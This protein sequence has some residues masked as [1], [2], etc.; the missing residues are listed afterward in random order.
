MKKETLKHL[1]QTRQAQG[2]GQAEIGFLIGLE[3]T[4]IC[5]IENGRQNILADHLLKW[6]NVLNIDPAYF[7]SLEF[8]DNKEKNM[9]E[10]TKK[11][12]CITVPYSETVEAQ[13]NTY[14]VQCK[15]LR[16]LLDGALQN[17]KP[18]VDQCTKALT[19][20]GRFSDE[21][22]NTLHRLETTLTSLKEAIMWLGMDLKA[23]NEPNPY[24]NSYNPEN[25]IV[26][27]TADGLKL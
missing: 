21:R 8:N 10:E 6:I 13:T 23:L 26:D 20:S 17:L 11:E 2:L 16:V 15:T 9:T 27:P 7:F 14:I 4:S 22:V 18:V 1:K 3:R 25:V 5:K 19:Q 12:V 24:P